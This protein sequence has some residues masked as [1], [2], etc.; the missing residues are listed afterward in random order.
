[1]GL[2]LELTQGEQEE[3]KTKGPKRFTTFLRP[4][5]ASQHRTSFY[6]YTLLGEVGA[7][8][9]TPTQKAK[10][11]EEEVEYGSP[12]MSKIVFCLWRGRELMMLRREGEQCDKGLGLQRRR[13]NHA[14]MMYIWFF[15]PAAQICNSKLGTEKVV[16][17]GC[18]VTL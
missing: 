2:L 3:I 12:Y 6:V 5:Y 15:S 17:V 14:L 18:L 4:V 11:E 7:E 13:A 1:M 16:C 10:K 8:R 9:W